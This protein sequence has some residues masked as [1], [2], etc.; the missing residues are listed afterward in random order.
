MPDRSAGSASP[1]TP[2]LPRSSLLVCLF[3]L[4]LAFSSLE[5]ERRAG[6]IERCYRPLLALARRTE[7][8]IAIE[9]PGW[10]LERIAEH[11]PSWLTDAR[12]LIETGRVEFVGSGYAQCA[13]PLLPAHVNRWNLRLGLDVYQRLLGTRPRVALIAEQAYSPGL[14]G[15]YREAGF[16][17]IVADWDNAF[18]SHPEWGPSVRGYPQVARGAD[19]ELPVVWSESIAFQKFQ[20]YAHGEMTLQA[21]VDFVAS[22]MESHR[23]ALTLYA[24]DA[25]V[26]DHRPGRFAAEPE[27]QEHE[28]DR[29]AD[30]LGALAAAG[31]GTPALPSEVLTLLDRPEAGEPLGLDAADQPIPVKNRTDTTSRAGRSPDA[32][33]S[34]S[35]PAADGSTSAYAQPATRSP[36]PG[37]SCASFGRQTSAPTSRNR[38]G[39]HCEPAWEPLSSG[40]PSGGVKVR[41]RLAYRA[42]HCYR[43]AFGV[44][45]GCF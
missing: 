17:A 28:W 43:T 29:I 6:V 19:A 30:A 40:C 20:R 11:D 9:A 25:E 4:N 38:G 12:D 10:T 13:A 2:A 16:E 24:N 14:V 1:T 36:K 23:G 3:H 41:L 18:R 21:Y 7:F 31:L 39:R 27:I 42:N 8:P 22:A 5:V 33:T 32:M 34:I 35:T 44:T 37:A 45:V 15:I 26:F